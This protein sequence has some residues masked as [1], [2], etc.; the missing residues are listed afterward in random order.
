MPTGTPGPATPHQ[1]ATYGHIAA[2]M[3]AF[4]KEK[5]YSPGDLNEAMGQVRSHTSVYHWLNGKA[6]PGPTTRPKLAK[7]MGISQAELM[8][9]KPGAPSASGAPSNELI[10][11]MNIPVKISPPRDVLSFMVQEDGLA[12]L[13][14]DVTMPLVTAGPLLRMLLDAGVVMGAQE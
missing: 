6:G 10:E 1:I 7:V 2:A 11:R 4:M 14:L 12:R 9:R 8:P 3:R 13:R 5:G